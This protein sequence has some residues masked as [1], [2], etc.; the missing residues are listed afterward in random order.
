MKKKVRT[1]ETKNLNI[2]MAT[3]AV[4]IKTPPSTLTKVLSELISLS[5][6]AQIVK[7]TPLSSYMVRK[8]HITP[9]VYRAAISKLYRLK[10]IVRS[11]GVIYLSPIIKTPFNEIKIVKK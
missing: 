2:L 3:L 5:D 8:L 1:I 11:D 9:E 6:N 4:G 7:T 10:L